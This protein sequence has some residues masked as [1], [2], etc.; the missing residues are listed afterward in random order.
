MLVIPS[1]NNPVNPIVKNVFIDKVSYGKIDGSVALLVTFASR[2]PKGSAVASRP[3]DIG[4]TPNTPSR[5]VAIPAHRTN[6][7]RCLWGINKC[8]GT[9]SAFLIRGFRSL[10]CRRQGGAVTQSSDDNS[11]PES[12]SGRPSSFDA[13]R[14]MHV[15]IT[16]L[17]L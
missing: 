13:S 10:N 2:H 9:A 6:L 5:H 8:F 7:R 12:L 1:V 3:L 4:V 14:Q 15:R 17:V 16:P 11:R